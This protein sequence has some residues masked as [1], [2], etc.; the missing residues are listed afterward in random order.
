MLRNMDT[1]FIENPNTSPDEDK[2]TPIYNASRNGHLEIIK[3]LVPLL[4]ADNPTSTA[5]DLA[6]NIA[7]HHDQVL[8]YLSDLPVYSGGAGSKKS[9]IE[10]I[11]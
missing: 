8:K 6:K 10:M 9:G 5:I 3:F 1:L 11:G 2:W 7:Y 4:L